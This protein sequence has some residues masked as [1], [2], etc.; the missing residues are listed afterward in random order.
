[1]TTQ[2]KC[3]IPQPNELKTFKLRLESWVKDTNNKEEKKLLKE[4]LKHLE[5][6][7]EAYFI[8]LMSIAQSEFGISENMHISPIYS[9]SIN[10]RNNMQKLRRQLPKIIKAYDKQSTSEEKIENIKTLGQASII[11]YGKDKGRD[12]PTGKNTPREHLDTLYI[13]PEN[14]QAFDGDAHGVEYEQMENP[15][16]D[17]NGTAAKLRTDANGNRNPNAVGLVVKK[18]AQRLIGTKIEWVDKKSDIE[19]VLKASFSLEDRDKF[20]LILNDF[21]NK[22]K[23]SLG[24]D[25]E[26]TY[27]RQNSNY[28]EVSTKADEDGIV[29][30][31]SFSAKKAKFKA[32]TTLFGTDVSGMTVEEVYQKIA[33]KSSKGQKPSK[34]SFI[35]G[36][37]SEDSYWEAY[38]PIWQKWAEQNPDKIEKLRKEAKSKVLTDA[39]ANTAVSQARALSDILNGSTYRTVW[40][41]ESIAM[42]NAGL[43]MQLAEDLQNALLS[44]GIVSSIQE[45]QI[46]KGRDIE[47][48]QRL[49]GVV[50][51][52]VAK[53]TKTSTTWSSMN[54]TKI[55]EASESAQATRPDDVSLHLKT[56]NIMT[57][58][59]PDI[60]DRKSKINTLAELLMYYLDNE[61]KQVQDMLNAIPDNELKESYGQEYVEIKHKI[62]D[63]DSKHN[64]LKGLL[65]YPEKDVDKKPL[66]VA[67]NDLNKLIANCS[68]E[69]IEEIPTSLIDIVYETFYGETPK[70]G[71]YFSDEYDIELEEG[72]EPSVKE[73]RQRAKNFIIFCSQLN[74]GDGLK[75]AMLNEATSIINE[76]TG[77]QISF[78]KGGMTL[79]DKEAAEIEDAEEGSADVKS[80]VELAKWKIKSPLDTVTARIKD[81]LRNAYQVYSYED[82]NGKKVPHYKRN[83]FGTRIPIKTEVTFY[84]LIEAYSEMNSSDDFDRITEEVLAKYPWFFEIY[85]RIKEDA[86][87]R[88]EFYRCM[89]N[90]LTTYAVVTKN[91]R[92]KILNNG[93]T[94]SIFLDNVQKNYNGGMVYT[95]TSLYDEEGKPNQ[96]N[97]KTFR[98]AYGPNERLKKA[99]KNANTKEEKQK[100]ILKLTPLGYANT[101][102]HD[103]NSNVSKLIDTLIILNDNETFNLENILKSIGVDTDDFDLSA[104]LPKIPV[105]QLL[106][107]ETLDELEV[108][109]P[110]RNRER[111]KLILDNFHT[112]IARYGTTSSTNMLEDYKTAISII[113]KQLVSTAQSVTALQFWD[114]E[115]NRN[116]Y[117]K[118]DFVST[119]FNAIGHSKDDKAAQE[120]TT[121]YLKKHY[122][123]DFF[124]NMPLIFSTMN[125]SINIFCISIQNKTLRIR[126]YFTFEFSDYAAVDTIFQ[127]RFDTF[128][129]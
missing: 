127:T 66:Q 106:D 112:I 75:E 121:L 83:V 44:L 125:K 3:F 113:G 115:H 14:L 119:L 4:A 22:V 42:V 25:K 26:F 99:N 70:K 61:I 68:C 129:L 16:I 60:A 67:V 45:S 82:N 65:Q 40:L 110:K 43:P 20:Q 81:L 96:D 9:T 73:L 46:T 56:I 101:V 54:K 12:L 93:Y 71:F 69:N 123:Y 86:D 111:V 79:N 31:S 33:K 32:G 87:L 105:E 13:F 114:G 107:I 47:D 88:N 98:E 124:E 76:R 94:V 39:F 53:S 90:V 18:D 34:L 38:L 19:D 49:Y 55:E 80:E 100:N 1:M 74:R 102:L 122:D 11:L 97:L 7:D 72:L 109:W 77:I 63:T 126:N 37:T 30:D 36:N 89:R 92:L 78:E 23:K 15:V 64:R 35:K 120:R 21:V 50:L 57:K 41:P 24:I 117:T 5:E 95:S 104:I 103:S 85:N 84:Y 8:A 28:Y 91:G 52:N 62:N 58:V 108:V 51:D 48:S 6:S 27:A 17:V 2:T 128:I 29:G 59:Y 10:D 118:P 116:S